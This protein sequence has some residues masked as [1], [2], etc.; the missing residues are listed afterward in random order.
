MTMAN[1]KKKTATANAGTKSRERL[2]IHQIVVKAP[3]RKV[4][5]VGNWRT[6]LSS[7][8]NG[9]TKQLYD[10]LDDIMIDG[11]LSD[12]VQK[13][14]DAVTNSELTFQ[15]ADG[16]EVEEIALLMD[17]TAWEELLTEIMKKKI[18]GRSGVEMTFNDGFNV[19]PI[20]AKH[21]NLKN[22]TILRQDTDETGIPYE[23]DSQLL[24]LG[25]DRDFGLLLKAAPYAIYKRGGFGDWS[26]WIELFGMPQRIGKYNT[27]DPES[28]KLLE[29]AFEKAG[30]AP[31]VVIPKEADVETKDGG[32]GSGASY[33]EFRQ[34]NNEEM[35]ITILGQTMTTVQGEKGARSLGEVHKEVEE[36]KNKSDLRYVQRVLNQKVLPMLEARGYPVTGGKFVFP[37]AA[38]QLSVAE[39]VQLSDIMDI[40]QSYLHEKYSIPVPKDGEPVAKRASSQAAQFDIGEDP[41]EDTVSNADRNFL[42]RLWDFFVKAPR[43]GA[44]GGKARI[45]L[46][47]DATLDGRVIARVAGGDSAYFDAELFQYIADDL[48]DAVQKAFKRTVN[49]ADVRFAYGLQ[50][51]A[52]ITA[53]EQNLFHFSAAKTLAEVQ[54]LNRMFRE[55]KNF[56]E[57]SKK[58]AEICGTFNKTWQKTEYETAVLTAESASNY[59]RLMGKTKLFPYWKYVT[60]GDDKVRE[61]HRK[62]DG[63]VLPAKDTRW[64]K[65]FPPNGWKCRCRVT[66]VMRHEVS[67]EWLAE[68]SRIVDGYLGTSEWRKVEQQHWDSN[69]GKRAEI[70]DK[71]QMYIRKFPD[72]AARYMDKIP[73]AGW[74]AEPSFKKLTGE[75][76]PEFKE[77]GGTAESWWNDRKKVMDGKDVLP[78]TDYRGR[79]WYMEKKDYDIHTTDDKKSR[80]FRVK[81]L[82]CIDE[83]MADPDEVWLGSEYK[84]RENPESRLNNW[85]LIKYYK[86]VA[87]ACVCKIEKR[88]M[89]F[90]SWYE[91]RNPKIRKGILVRKRQ[92]S[93]GRP[94]HD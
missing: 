90:K 18:Y 13:R 88:K 32:T 76:A 36:G 45:R 79:N 84:D 24:V 27:Y 41:E 11:V 75:K 53:L 71:D 44:S 94:V 48:L 69:R 74:G 55:S 23:G 10:L 78:V 31:Y 63:A 73:P 39:V 16:E 56:E 1:R 46:N 91:V 3:Q 37:K 50:D 81:Y 26:Q 5:D 12:A 20:P 43:D 8:D 22:R 29:E 52:F 30:S 51:D 89:V 66:P 62:L 4:Y 60:A 14:I 47:D 92:V 25:K 58:A 72:M 35:L 49:H 33:N 57:F 85:I 40:P 93:H 19:E 80:G 54:E 6:A 17:T 28:R 38:E 34:A 65:I 59:H 15:N 42:M 68:S 70:F 83:V 7:A 64:D 82:S 21:I 86:G 9:R 87:V 67:E 2:V 61:E 77:Y